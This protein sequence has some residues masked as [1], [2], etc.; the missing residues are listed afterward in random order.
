MRLQVA[1]VF[2]V[3]LGLSTGAQ[4][5]QIAPPAERQPAGRSP[6]HLVLRHVRVIDGTGRA[7]SD[8]Q[9]LVI[10]GGK[11]AAVGP[12][13][14]VAVPAGSEIRDLHEH[15]VLPGLVMLH[16]HL[17]Y[18]GGPDRL[19]F[20]DQPFSAPR[21]FLAFGVTT[22]REAGGPSNA[23]T[24]LNLKRLIDAGHTV[25]PEMFVSGP[26]IHAGPLDA[27][28]GMLLLAAAK[29]VTDANDARR[30][31]AHWASEGVS[32]FKVHEPIEAWALAAVID[33]AR[34]HRLPVLGHLGPVTC[35]EA[36]KLGIDFIEHGIESCETDLRSPNGE[37]IVDPDA[38]KARDLIRALVATR[39]TITET[40]IDA[41]T[42]DEEL[43][44]LH[45]AA[46][47]YYMKGAS[48]KVK[49][50]GFFSPE[51]LD[52]P[53]RGKPGLSV[54]FAR[55]GGRVVV[56]SDTGG[57]PRI[58]GFANLKSLRLLHE[59]LGFTPLEA[60]QIAT[61]NGAA[62]LGIANRTGSIAVG[63]EADLLV[64]HG[65]PSSTLAD[66][67]KV[68]LVLS[69]GRTYDP[70]ALLAEVKGQFGWW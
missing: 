12:S 35:L 59:E 26:P 55:A 11:I 14:D 68:R 16:E 3:V 6:D 7:P 62:A 34:K 37:T 46:R 53:R 43:E 69:N 10:S 2:G 15:T 58:P 4:S 22:I 56:G 40:P 49:P 5:R 13:R 67:S 60:I 44:V 70:N 36:A 27:G 24:W 65:D 64:V 63:K 32:S 47:E 20:R 21:L 31:V 25:G 17:S 19:S 18:G 45:P 23:Y 41:P 30:H 52:N 50:F 54:A 8:D 28:R 38:P 66:I 29:R 1:A 9:T 51:T 48:A 39:V 42:S 61:S 33:E 57:V